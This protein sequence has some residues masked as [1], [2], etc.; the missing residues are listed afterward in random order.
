MDISTFWIAC[1]CTIHRHHPYP[2]NETSIYDYM[3]YFVLSNCEKEQW[4]ETVLSDLWLVVDELQDQWKSIN[5]TNQSNKYSNLFTIYVN[6]MI[7]E[8]ACVS[9]VVQFGISNFRAKQPR[10]SPQALSS[11]NDMLFICCCFIESINEIY[12]LLLC[13]QKLQMNFSR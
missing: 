12:A 2:F 1:K 10:Q 5:N 7:C 11:I 9:G 3:L 4:N 6:W 8:C 13:I